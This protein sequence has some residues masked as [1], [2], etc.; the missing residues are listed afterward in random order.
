[1]KAHQRITYYRDRLSKW[2]E[3]CKLGH[4]YKEPKPED[5][6]IHSQPELFM[7]KQIREAVMKRKEQ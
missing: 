6:G 4:P 7:A 2:A 1:M 5:F 3:D